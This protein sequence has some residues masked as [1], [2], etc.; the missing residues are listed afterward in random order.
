MCFEFGIQPVASGILSAQRQRT[1]LEQDRE[2][3]HGNEPFA[4]R[5]FLH[6][7]RAGFC[8]IF[9]GNHNESRLEDSKSK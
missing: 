7:P 4:K 1:D 5:A 2:Q 8:G 9:G 3:G 6:V